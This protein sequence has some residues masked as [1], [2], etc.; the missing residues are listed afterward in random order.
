[1][2]NENIKSIPGGIGF[3]KIGKLLG[4]GFAGV[5]S[6]TKKLGSKIGS[7]AKGTFSKLAS[8]TKIIGGGIFKGIGKTLS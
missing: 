7:L 3:G 6:A 1:M 5:L 2:L 4:A 8:V